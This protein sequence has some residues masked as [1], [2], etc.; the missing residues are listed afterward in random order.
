ML[1]QRSTK[2]R[3]PAVLSP[4]GPATTLKGRIK[5]MVG[6]A[7][8][9]RTHRVARLR[10]LTKYRVVRD[11]SPN[12]GLRTKLAFIL[13]D[14]E[15]ES[16][17]Y[18]LA[19]EERFVAE[20]AE[21]LGE[22]RRELMRYARETHQDPELN[23]RLAQHNRW[24]FD[25]KRRPPLGHRLGWYLMARARKPSLIVETGIY[26]GLG[27]LALLRALERNRQE[28]FPGK[29]ISFDIYSAAGDVVRPELRTGWCRVIGST[30]DLLPP[31]LEGRAVD[32]MFQDTPHTIENQNFEF[33][34]ALRQAGERLL[35]LDGSG[36]HTPTLRRM[37]EEYEGVY[38]RVPSPSR[39][40]IYGGLGVAFAIF[41][42]SEAGHPSSELEAGLR[43]QRDRAG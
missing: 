6:P 4:A 42:R 41:D 8:Q 39:N 31:S 11:L 1:V 27:S 23:D 29:L 26:R 25:V 33:G 38:R 12:V 43:S 7:W 3:D 32:M 18:E 10:W 5:R 35:L 36:G 28:G 14:P 21:A 15:I 9:F 34:A 13:L 40:H 37:A 2:P 30:R 20:L 19:D 16:Y 22:S 17:S 24:R